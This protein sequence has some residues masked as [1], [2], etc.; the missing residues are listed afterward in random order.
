MFHKF[1]VH[2]KLKTIDNQSMKN[3]VTDITETFMKSILKETDNF[4]IL[5]FKVLIKFIPF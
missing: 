3:Q 1:A 5:F 4:D 2:F